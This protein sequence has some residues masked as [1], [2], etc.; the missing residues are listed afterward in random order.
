VLFERFPRAARDLAVTQAKRL[1]VDVRDAEVYVDGRVLER[2]GEP[3]LHIVRNAIDHGVELP[4][5]REAAGKS[6][7]ATLRLHAEQVASSIQVTIE[8]D[9]RG[10]DLVAVRARALQQGLISEEQVGLLSTDH[11]MSLIFRPGFSTRQT[12]TDVSGRGVGLDAVART[13]ADL[14]GT[15]RVKSEPGK[16]TKFI[17]TVPGSLLLKP[18]LV[19]RVGEQE[20]AVSAQRVERVVRLVGASVENVGSRRVVRVD[21]QRIPLADL[22]PTLGVASDTSDAERSALVLSSS[23]R[24]AAFVVD[25]VL[26]QKHVLQRPTGMFIAGHSLLE[27]VAITEAGN[28]VLLLSPDRLIDLLDQHRSVHV[29]QATEHRPRHSVLVVDDSEVTREL[30]ASI[31]RNEGL[32]VVE[33][34]NGRDALDRLRANRPAVVVSDLEMPLLDGF[35]LLGEIRRT[36]EFADLPV[37]MFTTRGSESDKKRG[38]QLGA[39]AYLVKGNFDENEL[40][41]T[42]RRFLRPEARS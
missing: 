30:I 27:G 36:Q 4:A 1:R 41:A 18:V 20:F 7:T 14:N 29:A 34:V 3:L 9:G 42:V 40:I 16:G 35:G 6:P 37:I 12:A 15:V 25:A 11:L 21:D 26:G 23:G 31:L 8:D 2:L 33:A 5:E 13:L 22:G 32:D 24:S 28:A 38:A 17:L 10:V 39:S 19:A